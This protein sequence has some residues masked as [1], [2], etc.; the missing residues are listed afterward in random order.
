MVSSDSSGDEMVEGEVATASLEVS[1][2]KG[3][4]LSLERATCSV[5]NLSWLLLRLESGRNR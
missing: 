2:V 1:R 3:R 4:R 5:W